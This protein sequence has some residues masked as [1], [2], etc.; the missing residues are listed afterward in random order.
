MKARK[1]PKLPRQWVYAFKMRFVSRVRDE[2]K[3]R[4][5]RPKR[6]DGKRPAPG[7]R[8]SLRYW[9]GKPYW[10]KQTLIY[11]STI[12]AVSTVVIEQGKPPR[13][14]GVSL[15]QAAAEQ[16]ALYDGFDDF[17][18]MLEW[19]HHEHGDRVELDMIEWEPRHI[20]GKARQKRV[21]SAI[22]CSLFFPRISTLPSAK[23]TCQRKRPKLRRCP[24]RPKRQRRPPYPCRLYRFQP[25]PK[26][27]LRA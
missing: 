23:S 27:P 1:H 18:D 9:Q 16:F 2:R 3:L 14:E 13:V 10:S 22:N 20:N 4:T 6:K 7:D 19:F 26:R 11:N 17:A 25:T 12:K 24:V 5:M 8:I 15:T 21:K